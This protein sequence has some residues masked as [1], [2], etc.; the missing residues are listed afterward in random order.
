DGVHCTASGEREVGHFSA[1]LQDAKQVK[2]CLLVHRLGRPSDVTMTV[3]DGIGRQPT[4]P[5]QMLERGGKQIAQFWRSARPLIWN[6][7]A[8]M[9]KELQIEREATTR[10]QAHNLAHRVKER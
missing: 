7:L 6:V 3:L 2:E 9:A 1:L 4:R 8:M 5:K 10:E